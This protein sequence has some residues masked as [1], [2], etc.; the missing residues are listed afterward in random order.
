MQIE[1]EATFTN[2]NKEG[3]RE[4]LKKDGAELIKPEFLQRRVVFNMPK[5]YEDNS[6]WIRARD[7]GDKITMSIKQAGK[8]SNQIH[9]IKELKL[10][11]D[12]FENAEKFLSTLHCQKKSYQET[13]REIWELDGVEICLDEW[14]YLEPLME[15]EGNNEE[16]VK[17]TSQKLGLDYG[18]AKFCSATELY[19]EKYGISCD[20]IN[21]GIPEITF[22]GKNPFEKL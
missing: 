17:N 6:V 19:S 18:K 4:K 8:D 3:I 21:N 16:S 15:I 9:N 5:G 22:E 11:V 20:A 10:I 13:K 12:S 1:Y 14:P 2:I 7:E